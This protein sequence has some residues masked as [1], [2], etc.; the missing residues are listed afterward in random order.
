MFGDGDI[1]RLL[2]QFG[3]NMMSTAHTELLLSSG[4]KNP[5]ASGSFAMPSHS[6]GVVTKSKGSL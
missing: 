1:C 4:N 5:V 2:S 6:H 3:M